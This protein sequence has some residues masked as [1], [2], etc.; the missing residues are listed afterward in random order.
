MFPQGKGGK[1]KHKSKT[2]CN[3]DSITDYMKWEKAKVATK[4]ERHSVLVEVGFFGTCLKVM[5]V[6]SLIGCLRFALAT[7]E[8]E[9]TATTAAEIASS[10]NSTSYKQSLNTDTHNFMLNKAAFLYFGN[11][12]LPCTIQKWLGNMCWH[13]LL[14]IVQQCKDQGIHNCH[15]CFF[16]LS[17]SVL[18]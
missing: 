2:C 12:N 16:W 17:H 5:I 10:E 4:M 11:L 9:T 3:L 1:I 7:A 14:Q 13:F 15:K 18:N 8:I 6:S